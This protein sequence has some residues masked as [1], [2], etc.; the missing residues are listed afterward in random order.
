MHAAV[1]FGQYDYAVSAG[2]LTRL[3][4]HLNLNF[5]YKVLCFKD[6]LSKLLIVDNG[7]P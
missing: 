2:P 1:D 5:A 3:R 7:K 4:P 6:F